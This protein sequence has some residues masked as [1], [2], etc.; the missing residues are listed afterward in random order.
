M[1]KLYFV[2][3]SI[4]CLPL[5][6]CRKR[7]RYDG[8][9]WI[10]AQNGP[11][12]PYNNSKDLDWLAKCPHCINF[13]ICA[14]NCLIVRSSTDSEPLL[15]GLWMALYQCVKVCQVA[16][17]M[18]VFCNLGILLLHSMTT[19]GGPDE[20]PVRDHSHPLLRADARPHPKGGGAPAPLHEALQLEGPQRAYPGFTL[21]CLSLSSSI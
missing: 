21:G 7:L 19:T 15:Q 20:Q 17:M 5:T 14:K 10:L 3:Q 13:Q 12:C 18:D 2:L 11:Q 1:C 8:L 16:N 9:W 4:E 6:G